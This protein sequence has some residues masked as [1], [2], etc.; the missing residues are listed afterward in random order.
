MKKDARNKDGYSSYC[1]ACHQE[2]SVAWQKAN[3]DRLNASR[4]MRYA[5]IKDK[6][7]A[8]RRSKYSYDD[9]RWK[10][11]G[12]L[13]KVTRE[14]YEAQLAAQGF[15][16]AICGATDSQSKRAFAVDHD[17]SCC[18]KAPTCGKC[19]RGILCHHCNVALHSVEKGTGW[20]ESAI[21]YLKKMED[22][23]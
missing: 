22:E 21:S 4:R 3:P 12:Y 8:D 20:L 1:K 9:V 5:K 2:A 18:A 7:N 13:Y 10:R 14:W 11:I 19:T 15:V 16:C 17:H 23:K 6:L